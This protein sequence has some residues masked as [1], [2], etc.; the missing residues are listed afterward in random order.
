MSNE[1]VT[2][3]SSPW[4][5]EVM[6]QESTGNVVVVLLPLPNGFPLRLAGLTVER[7]YLSLS[8]GSIEPKRPSA[9]SLIPAQKKRVLVSPA[10][11][12]FPKATPHR[13]LFVIA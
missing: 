6:N 2:C 11:P 4:S 1:P 7:N 9:S 13:P 3:A 10:R 12:P 5:V 8:S